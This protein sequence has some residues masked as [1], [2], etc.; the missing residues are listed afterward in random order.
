MGEAH[1]RD[2]LISRR[3]IADGWIFGDQRRAAG[4]KR[5]GGPG[6]DRRDHI[7]MRL[8]GEVQHPLTTGAAGRRTTANPDPPAL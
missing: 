2:Q 3:Q 5:H 7:G 6:F 1:S 8:V 4:R